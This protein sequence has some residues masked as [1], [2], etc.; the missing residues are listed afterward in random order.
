MDPSRPHSDLDTGQP[1]PE[2]PRSGSPVSRR[3]VLR[4]GAAL[5]GAVALGGGTLGLAAPA[6]AGPAG[7]PS[8]QYFGMPFDKSKLRYNPSNELIFPCIKDTSGKLTGAR[9]R[10]YLYYAPHEAP[11]GICLAYCN[12]LSGPFTEYPNNP[13]VKNVWSPYYS[14]SHVSSPHVIWN[15]ST[16]RYHLYFHGENSATRMATSADGISWAYASRV[17]STANIPGSTE[18]SY[19]RVFEHTITGKGNRYVMLFMVVTSGT[20]KIH[21]GWSNDLTNWSFSTTPLLRPEWIN[22]IDISGPQLMRRNGTAYV[23][24]HGNYGHMYITEV[25]NGFDKAVQLG[26]FF[27]PMSGP[28]DSGRVAAPSFVSDGDVQYMFYEAGQRLSASIAI[29][30][31]I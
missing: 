15:D 24:Y 4:G 13:I 23:I 21:Y 30:K 9:A 19:A 22:Q 8:Y 20:R 3:A 28:P 6:F 5:G 11:G 16:K 26:H 2:D 25:G 12:S 10:Y 14:V 7:F 17:L 27:D 31:A 1:F 18:T 29:A